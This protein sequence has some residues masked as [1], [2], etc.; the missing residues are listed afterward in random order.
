MACRL[1]TV[2][3]A[4]LGQ[5]DDSDRSS[6]DERRQSLN[7]PAT[8]P[9]GSP[10]NF[11]PRGPVKVRNTLF[12]DRIPSPLDLKLH[13]DI[14]NIAKNI[15]F[16]DIQS[17]YQ[18]A[19]N[20]TADRSGAQ[21]FLEELKF[22]VISS[23]LCEKQPT[24]GPLSGAPLPLHAPKPDYEADIYSRPW[25]T[26]GAVAAAALGFGCAALVRWFFIGGVF[27][28][29]LKRSVIALA[30]AALVAFLIRAYMRRQWVKYIYEQA[31]IETDRFVRNSSEFDNAISSAVS[32]VL[33]VELIARGY[34]LS[35]PLPPVTRLENNGQALKSG[36]IR[37]ALNDNF[38]DVIQTYYEAA[39]VIRDFADE[40]QLNGYEVAKQSEPSKVK[41]SM[42]NFVN[43]DP[44]EAQK[45]I[46]LRDS[47]QLS[48][49]TRKMFLLGL[50]S[51]DS[52]GSKMDLLRFT[53]AL[54]G[55]RKCNRVT[56]VACYRMKTVLL[57]DGS[58]TESSAMKSP[59]SPTHI[60]WK[61]QIQKVG[62]MNL[63]I[64]TLQAK[65]AL[66]ADESTS[67]LNKADDISELGPM[68]M[69]QYES[70]GKDL[71]ELLEAW[72]AGKTDLASNIDRNQRRVSSI[73]ATL[74]PI[75]GLPVMAA[76]LEG[77][78]EAGGRQEAL[79][80]LSGEAYTT[81]A[82]DAPFSP[83]EAHSKVTECFEAIATSRPRSMLNRQERLQKMQDERA[84]KTAA[85][86][87]A[88]EQGWIMGEL[89]DVLKIRGLN[90]LVDNQNIDK[91]NMSTEAGPSNYRPSTRVP[92]F[93]GPKT[94]TA[95]TRRNTR[96]MSMPS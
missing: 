3:A 50:I 11:A 42:I 90:G 81:N 34:R 70:I 15:K 10:Q 59:Q 47:L 23:Q 6:Q 67:I 92:N 60:R 33:E 16:D 57:A 54:E 25:T 31:L 41:E 87:R 24:F 84:A 71:R 39:L 29:T 89:K 44:E 8:S 82:S 26:N 51:L 69:S 78:G 76:V 17:A 2:F 21:K 38:I 74:S 52:K 66:L 27:T 62:S 83:E 18:T 4:G 1:L 37:K 65:M 55:I 40:D 77:D 20:S 19:V 86:D 95:S 43:T 96:I 63:N 85:R 73:S 45:T 12:R 13:V 5:E 88:L 14:P 53:T 68:F 72:E 30:A 64:R 35:M 93:A 9:P 58:F 36:K 91:T 46:Q 56:Q 75:S 22:L 32:F 94:P 61:H 80:K 49:E 79:R 28:I 48:R 7:T